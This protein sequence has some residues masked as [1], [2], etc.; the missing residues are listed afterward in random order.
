MPKKI[1]I[2]LDDDLYRELSRLA[3]PDEVVQYV[4]DLIRE[5][6]RLPGSGEPE[7]D[8]AADRVREQEGPEWESSVVKVGARPPKKL[9]EKAKRM[10]QSA[11]PSRKALKRASAAV[12]LPVVDGAEVGL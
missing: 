8:V 5:Q 3:G 1:T 4:E 12:R 10:L 9:S 2:S 11:K 6:L 7:L